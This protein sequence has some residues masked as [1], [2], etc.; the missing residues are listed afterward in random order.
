MHLEE[1][2]RRR[3]FAEDD[4]LGAE[5]GLADLGDLAFAQQPGER[6]DNVGRRPIMKRTVDQD[7]G[8]GA[9]D[10]LRRGTACRRSGSRSDG[11]R[12]G[13]D[14]LGGRCAHTAAAGTRTGRSEPSGGAE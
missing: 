3:P 13:L 14:L 7:G 11:R 10:E 6:P 9:E 8:V 4:P 1:T 2:V 5:R 12:G